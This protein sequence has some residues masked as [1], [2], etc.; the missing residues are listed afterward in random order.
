MKKLIS[1]LTAVLTLSIVASASAAENSVEYDV[2]QQNAVIHISNRSDYTITVKVMRVNGG[3]YTT[4]TIGPRSSS[5]VS[6]EKSGDFY[7]AV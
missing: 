2:Y 7:T 5:S 4:R 6:F 1:I 3:L